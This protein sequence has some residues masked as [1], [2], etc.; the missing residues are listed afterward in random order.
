MDTWKPLKEF[1]PKR[2]S[3]FF[4]YGFLRL[5]VWPT[6]RKLIC[7]GNGI[8]IGELNHTF[9]P[10]QYPMQMK[11]EVSVGGFVNSWDLVEITSLFN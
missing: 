6:D 10:D 8:Q 5:V 2:R 7:P 4:M 3:S 11:L 1:N 9:E